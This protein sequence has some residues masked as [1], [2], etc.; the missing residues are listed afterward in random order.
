MT[1]VYT[2][3][4]RGLR[5]DRSK[6]ESEISRVNASPSS[7]LRGAIVQPDLKTAPKKIEVLAVRQ[8]YQ[9]DDCQLI[10]LST[11][12]GEIQGRYYK[13]EH[14]KMGAIWVGGVGGG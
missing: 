9:P 4:Y 6:F 14:A 2:V 1:C 12:R 8:E 7:Y 3:A 11:N 13:A 10:R 5:A